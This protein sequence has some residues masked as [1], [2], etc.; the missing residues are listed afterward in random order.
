MVE[1]AGEEVRCLLSALPP[2]KTVTGLWQRR[3]RRFVVAL[4]LEGCLALERGTMVGA[5]VLRSVSSRAPTLIPCQDW[6][7]APHTHYMTLRSYPHTVRVDASFNQLLTSILPYGMTV[8][9]IPGT[10]HFLGHLHHQ[11]CR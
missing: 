9:A 3:V 4:L 10:G 1:T 6:A 11:P 8:L 2:D 7:A 5:H